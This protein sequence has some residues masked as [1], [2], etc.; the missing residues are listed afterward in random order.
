MTTIGEF[1]EN[2]QKLNLRK[3]VPIIIEQTS[4]EITTLIQIQLQDGTNSEGRKITPK[5]KSRSY[6]AKKFNMNGGAGFGTPDLFLTGLMYKGMG[7]VVENERFFTV[8]SNVPY[9]GK[10]E[11]YYGDVTFGMSEKSAGEYAQETVYKGI[12][13]YVSQ[14]TGLN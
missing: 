3:Q 14:I 5:Y 1:Y 4:Y 11:S 13:N 2:I 7:V 12:A 8:K 6:A 9:F 10:L